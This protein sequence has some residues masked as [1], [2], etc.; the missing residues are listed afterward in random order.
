MEGGVRQRRPPIPAIM[1]AA[2]LS[3]DPHCKLYYSKQFQK[4]FQAHTQADPS[5]QADQGIGI[6]GRARQYS[7]QRVRRFVAPK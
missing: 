1:A 5:T 7:Q 3:R 2:L 4:A 6:G